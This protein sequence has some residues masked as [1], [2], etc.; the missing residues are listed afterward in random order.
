MGTQEHQLRD[1]LRHQRRTNELQMEIV[2]QAHDLD[3]ALAAGQPELA[4]R[5]RDSMLVAAVHLYLRER[6]VDYT[7][8]DSWIG[9]VEGAMAA[10]DAVHAS[11]ADEVWRHLAESMPDGQTALRHE[12]DVALQLIGTRLGVAFARDEAV[13]QWA[14]G[15]KLLR[16]IAL[17]IGI[18]QGDAWYLPENPDGTDQEH[19]YDEIMR[20]LESS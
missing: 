18:A 19:W 11:L 13:R 9:E 1:W 3:G 16:E 10:L 6:G 14:G 4:W 5:A 8:G 2:A 20:V 15:V 17:A 12:I 7:D